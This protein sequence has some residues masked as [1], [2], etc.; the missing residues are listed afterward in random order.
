MFETSLTLRSSCDLYMHYINHGCSSENLGAV[1]ETLR[2]NGAS[3]LQR[4]VACRDQ[5]VANSRPFIR[6]GITILTHGFSRVVCGIL[7]AH[8][9]VT[10]RLLVAEGKPFDYGERTERF[11]REHGARFSIERIFD[12]SVA[13]RMKEVDFVLVGSQMVVMTGGSI[14]SVGSYGIALTAKCFDVPV[15]V[16]AECFKFYNHFPIEQQDAN[17]GL[18]P[19]EVNGIKTVLYDYTPPELISLLFTDLAVFTPS[20]VADELIKLYGM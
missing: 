1:I 13:Y 9:D 18:P 4:L 7:L 3:L 15:Y 6:P 10:F 19:V 2:A 12:T 17:M 20:A 5:I 16:A 8:R 11:L 14:N